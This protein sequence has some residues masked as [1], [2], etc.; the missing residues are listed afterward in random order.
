MALDCWREAATMSL[1]ELVEGR[2]IHITVDVW[3]RPPKGMA[4]GETDA[5]IGVGRGLIRE[6]F[7]L[8]KAAG[9]TEGFTVEIEARQVVI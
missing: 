8:L 7:M 4:V 2:T 5:A 1:S 3:L 9:E 6:A